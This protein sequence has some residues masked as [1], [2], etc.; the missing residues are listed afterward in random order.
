MSDNWFPNVVD[1]QVDSS[2]FQGIAASASE[3]VVVPDA[4]CLADRRTWLSVRKYHADAAARPAVTDF[5]TVFFCTPQNSRSTTSYTVAV[6]DV[7]REPAPFNVSGS[8]G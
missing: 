6:I 4:D 5:Q 2:Q 8:T 1:V 7:D 3:I